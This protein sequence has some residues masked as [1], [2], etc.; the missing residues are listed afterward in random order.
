MQNR[1]PLHP[2]DGEIGS[3]AYSKPAEA[4]LLGLG[5]TNEDVDDIRRGCAN[6]KPGIP[7]LTG[8]L[9]KV[10]FE[11]MMRTNPL[12]APE[13]QGPLTAEKVKRTLMEVLNERKG[14]RDGVYSWW[15]E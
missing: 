8:G 2:T 3:Q 14:G 4:V 5:Y 1:E 11:E 15:N 6:I 7:W 13:Q 9:S 10:D 12:P